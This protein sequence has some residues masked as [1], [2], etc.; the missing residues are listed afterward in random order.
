VGGGCR[1]WQVRVLIRS[2]AGIVGQRATLDES[3]QH[4]L[5]VRRAR[6]GE[7][8][9]LLDGAGLVATGR[10]IRDG[11]EWA[12]EVD[13]VEQRQR[14]PELTLAVAAGDR[15]RFSWLVEKSV[16]LGVTCIVPLET[17]RTRDVG[18]RLR[19]SHLPKLRRLA[20]E[21]IKQCGAA[22]VSTVEAPLELQEFLGRPVHG[23]CWLA[24]A[25]GTLPP[26]ALDDAPVTIIIGP[27]GGFGSEER[28]AV[29]KAGYSAVALSLQTLRF[30]TAAL[31][32]AALVGT[33]RMRGQRG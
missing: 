9:E 31:A 11:T 7:K 24:D 12:A 32:A 17:A 27:E 3:E 15:E 23:K 10:L 33:A 1:A 30:E 16:E 14:P 18:T 19:D 29:M 13:R 25:G 26:A 28:A 2:G 5:K 20:L 8:V 4:H 6:E 21:A 22:W